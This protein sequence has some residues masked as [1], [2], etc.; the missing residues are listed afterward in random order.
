[1]RAL[2]IVG[3]NA[4]SSALVT[5]PLRSRIYR[6]VITV[7]DVGQSVAVINA[8]H[9]SFQLRTPASKSGRYHSLLLS[10]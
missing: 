9:P 2:C 7:C 6:F 3:A 10:P 1:M 8:G 5:K 4:V